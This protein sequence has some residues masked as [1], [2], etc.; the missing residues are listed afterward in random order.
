MVD[1]ERWGAL[2][3]ID[4][5]GGWNISDRARGKQTLAERV[6]QANSVA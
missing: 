2:A 4:R 1:P 5:L 3:E 6:E